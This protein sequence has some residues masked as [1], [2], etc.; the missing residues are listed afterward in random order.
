MYGLL[1]AG[2]GV[3]WGDVCL[4]L[5]LARLR[6]WTSCCHDWDPLRESDSNVTISAVYQ[7]DSRGGHVEA[8]VVCGNVW[9][10]TLFCLCWET[11]QQLG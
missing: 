11:E 3:G 6:V 7:E 5:S 4:T 2:G 8:R 10:F 9:C 1:D